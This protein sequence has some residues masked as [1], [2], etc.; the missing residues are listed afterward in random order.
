MIL[1]KKLTTKLLASIFVLVTGYSYGQTAPV[2]ELLHYRFDGTGTSIPNLASAPPA[3]TATATIVGGPTQGSTGQCGG[4]LIGTGASSASDYVNTAWETNL[5]GT[6]WTIS[7]WTSNVPNT[8]STQY[9]LGDINAG[10]LRVFTGGVAGGGNWILRGAFT[11][12]YAN[13]GAAVGPTLTTFVYDMPLNEIRSYVN[14]VLNQTVAQGMVAITGTGPFKVGGYSSSASLP[15]GSLMDE[16]RLYSHALTQAEINQL[17]ITGST[18]TVNITACG[19]YTVPSGGETYTTSGTYMD[20]IPNVNGCD[21]V[22][23]LNLTINSPSASTIDTVAC[24]SYD[25]PS[26]MYTWT[27]SGTYLDTIPNAIGCDSVITVNLTINTPTSSTITISECNSYESPSGNYTWITSGTYMD[28]VPNV[29]GCD[30][31]ITVN[32]TINTPTSSTITVSECDTYESPSGNYTWNIS[33]MYMD[34]ILNMNGC[35]SVIMINLTI[36]DPMDVSITA[37]M[38]TLTVG[39]SGADYQW[40]TCPAYTAISGETNQSFTATANGDYAVIVTGANCSDTSAC[41]TV[42]NVSVAENSLSDLS[43]FPNPVLTTLK[44]SNPSVSLLTIELFDAAG[45]SVAT[46]QSQSKEISI[47]MNQLESG[48][49]FLKAYTADGTAKTFRIVKN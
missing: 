41:Y 13:G 42:D 25:S 32:L 34:T 11:D 8:T 20:T 46:T 15:S 43:V 35:D 1:T 19:S 16:F 24:E 45:K 12:V 30:S 10:Q 14:G 37:D 22:M 33:G 39:E 48:I 31:V 7:F 38:T 47:D 40:V 29:L 5:T 23:T 18:S 6:S 44:I 9:I 17:F 21:S 49:Y 3:G 2:P 36:A 27:T 28:T 4:A 26:G